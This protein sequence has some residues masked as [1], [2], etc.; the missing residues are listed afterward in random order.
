MAQTVTI[1][2]VTPSSSDPC[3]TDLIP[4]G[5]IYNFCTITGYSWLPTTGL[6]CG[7]CANPTATPATTTTYTLTMSSSTCA[8]TFATITISPLGAPSAGTIYGP[9]T[10]CSGA[11]ISLTE[12]YSTGTWSSSTPTVATIDGSGVVYGVSVGT[13]T[14]T[15]TVS[16]S[17]GTAFT[18]YSVNVAPA[19]NPGSISGSTTLCAGASTTLSETVS[20]GTWSSSNTGVATI[21]ASGNL[22]GVSTGSATISYAVTNSCGT[23][24]AFYN[25]TVTGPPSVASITGSATACLGTLTTLSDATPSGAWSSS[26]T[27]IATVDASGGVIGVT[28]GSV[29]ITYAVSNSCGT[30]YATYGMSVIAAPS[31]A[32]AAASPN[33]LCSGSSLSLTGSAA[34][35]TSYSWSGP[36]SYSAA[37]QNPTSFTVNALSAGV[38]T[39]TATNACGSA[40]ATA[41]VTVVTTPTVSAI[42][43]TTPF[44]KGAMPVTFTCGPTGGSWS[45]AS[46]S[47]RLTISSSGVV[48]AGVGG[49]A[50]PS[51]AVITYSITNMCGSASTTLSIYAKGFATM[52]GTGYV[53]VG[54]QI[55]ISGSPSGGTWSYADATH[56]TASGAVPSNVVTAVSTGGAP[57]VYYAAPDNS[58]YCSTPLV[59][60]RTLFISNGTAYISGPSSVQATNNIP[61]TGSTSLGGASNTGTW[62]SSNTA[63]ATVITPG[64]TTSVYGVSVGSV[65]IMYTG[66]AACPVTTTKNITVVCPTC[67]PARESGAITKSDDDLQIYPNPTN[68]ELTVQIPD[69][70]IA[71]AITITDVT[72]KVIIT[73]IDAENEFKFDFSRYPTGVYLIKVDAGDR[74]Y[75]GKIIRN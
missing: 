37:V 70:V 13:T 74:K 61:L 40:S 47:N 45:I 72:G 21:D 67:K 69:G 28:I 29:T 5:S 25:I 60:P 15:Y 44:C 10:V 16:G 75:T 53:C 43:G 58:D 32:S 57:G 7:A 66:G 46:P 54:G 17:C 6:S 65:T 71:T 62:S 3:G 24:Y 33:P 41:T 31:S 2:S 48:T 22:W 18:T 55:T 9:S 19:A 42:S 56:F 50:S 26:N 51:S 35:A 39:F 30:S 1:N 63:I 49:N 12:T 59:G 64:A 38:Y 36:N 8:S 68:G 11:T 4:S 52:G 34:G 23:A 20:G 14:I 27:A 73:K